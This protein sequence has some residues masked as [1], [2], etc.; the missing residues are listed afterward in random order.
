[1]PRNPSVFS[2]LQRSFLGGGGEV[3]DSHALNAVFKEVTASPPGII[4]LDDEL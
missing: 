1:M 3:Y 4:D 2:S